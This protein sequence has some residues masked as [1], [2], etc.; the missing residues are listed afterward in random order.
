MARVISVLSVNQLLERNKAAAAKHQPFSYITEWESHGV[1]PPQVLVVTCADPRCTPE[2]YLGLKPGDG[3][4]VIRNACG[5]V[6]PDLG[7]ILGIDTLAVFK[8]VMIVHHTDCGAT[9]FKDEALREQLA[10][11]APG[12]KEIDS[13]MF[14]GIEDVEQSV[15]DDVQLLKSTPFLRKELVDHIYGFVLDIKT[16]ELS[17]VKE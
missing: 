16:G 17:P 15:R 4:I 7:S 8:E 1:Q 11:R 14:G 9:Y 5:H 2:F 3:V 12:N 13:L 6:V 10:K